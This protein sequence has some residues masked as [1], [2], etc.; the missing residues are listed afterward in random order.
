MGRSCVTRGDCPPRNSTTPSLA[1][2]AIR[3]HT[4]KRIEEA[5]ARAVAG[6]DSQQA[7]LNAELA[8]LDDGGAVPV[9]GPKDPMQQRP[10]RSI[11]TSASCGPPYPALPWLLVDTGEDLWSHDSLPKRLASACC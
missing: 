7:H 10:G 6:A 5:L 9:P 8:T 11:L 2:S 3:T 4:K 1:L